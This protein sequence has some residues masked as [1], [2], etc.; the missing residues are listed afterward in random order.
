MNTHD[1]LRNPNW[2]SD[3]KTLFLFALFSFVVAFGL[4][5]LELP[6]WNNQAYMVNGEFIMGTH[7]AYY[8]LAGAKG[9]G[10]AVGKPIVNILKLIGSITGCQY[11]NIAF[12][13]PAVFSGLT[14]VAAFAWGGL[15]G[16]NWVGLCSAV[17]A[18]SIPAFYFRTRLSYYDTDI[19][20]LLFPL[21]ITF[22]LA[23]FIQRGIYSTWLKRSAFSYKSSRWELFLPLLAGAVASYGVLWHADMQLFALV[24]LLLGSFLVLAVGS[25]ES[26]PELLRG[27]LIYAISAFFGAWGIPVAFLV[28]FTLK[29]PK[30]QEHKLYKNIFVYIV[31]ICG[32]FL[33]SGAGQNLGVI[34]MKKI[35][36][37][38]KP[39]ADVSHIQNGPVYPGIAQSVIEA[40]NLSLSVLFSQMIGNTTLGWICTASVVYFFASR[41]YS[42]LLLPFVLATFASVYIGGRFAMFGGT[43]F[44]LS[45]AVL[46]QDVLNKIFK[47]EKSRYKRVIHAAAGITVLGSL[48]CNTVPMYREYAITPIMS[49]Q[50]VKALIEAGKHMP[51]DSTVWTWWDWGY[52]TMYYA[53]VNTLANGGNHAGKVLFPLS[54]AYTTPSYLQSS[55]MIKFSAA[56][57]GN[58]WTELNKLSVLQ[59]QEFIKS[60]GVKK[61]QFKKAPK[62]YLVTCWENI[63]L[64][65]WI[66]YYG[67]WDLR[68]KGIHPIVQG[69]NNAFTFDAEN[70]VFRQNGRPPIK[71]SGYE[72]LSS[73]QSGR[74][75]FDLNAGPNLVYNADSKQAYLMDDLVANSV[76]FKLL[77][78]GPSDARLNNH[79]RIVYDG[80]P[81]I[82]IYEVI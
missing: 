40:Q 51:K 12:W 45:F 27:M 42:M 81:F 44:G 52:A 54:L 7:D 77:T 21:L 65:Y 71:V 29:S 11:G 55:Q 19:V 1:E 64:A 6:K 8:W 56:N 74:S 16:G 79:F 73:K 33:L 9:I 47:L 15:V 50:H 22:L 17:F 26:R 2:F 43:V 32:V 57:K 39:T 41:P 36:V 69:V 31:A 4:R 53:G 67:T 3:W 46:L 18:T 20:T 58:P 72:Y 49:Q 38:L 37:Y 5:L 48:L 59:A 14:A 76:M 80:F 13:L 75:R 62:Q 78:V 24:S 68:K 28:L 30:V 10:S 25:S 35:A 60:L 34:V 66:M 63:K 23:L 61:Y 70:G 82:R